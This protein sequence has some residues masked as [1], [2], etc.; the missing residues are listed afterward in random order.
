M[1]GETGESSVVNK[2][3]IGQYS[4]DRSLCDISDRNAIPDM[5]RYAED[6]E[7]PG[8]VRADCCRNGITVAYNY[9]LQ[10]F[11]QRI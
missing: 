7:V 5:K 8:I 1:S 3:E 4:R 6:S 10:R 2:P 9:F 11:S